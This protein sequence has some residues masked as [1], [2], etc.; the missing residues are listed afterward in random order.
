MGVGRTVLVTGVSR[1][2]GRTFARTLATDPG[3][4][5]VIGVDVMPPRGDLGDVTFVRADIRNPVIAKVIAKEDVDTVVHMSVIA[6]PGS[7]GAR[8]T[9]KEL[10]VI[11]S[12][13]LLAACQK[14]ETVRQLVVKS[15][16]TAYGASSRDPAMFTEDMEPRRPPRSGYAKDVNEVERYVRG[17]A[18]RRPD[19]T[20]TLL[21]CANVIGPRVVSPLA[22]YF[23]LPVIPTVLGF[24]P[25]LQ[26]LHETDL[27]RV[28]RHAVLSD[29]AGTFNV[30]GDGLLMLSQAL[31]RMG[32]TSVPLPGPAFGGVGSVLKSARM[33]DL[34][35][36]LV[37]F[38]TYGRG[39]D[40]TRMR[41]ELGF[42]P[43]Y[44]TAAAFAE[45]VGTLP[46]GGRRA[47]RVLAS[48]AD[49]LPPV[50]EDR[51]AQLT[52]AG[53]KDG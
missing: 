33:A 48:L 2:L 35:P 23:R 30:A 34:S 32:R 44:S 13:Q 27:N 10:N 53:G 29:V 25:R 20:V 47:E 12:M 26:F 49:R 4:N 52:V 28:L 39:V 22:S 14:A 1:D 51:P 40:T 9:M 15:S 45:F 43:S 31:R 7:A 37:A 18:R 19:V 21:R 50:D 11:G 38:L 36:E 8:G 41:T 6:T 5:R 24:D 42:E 16:T 46:P 3:V 17:F